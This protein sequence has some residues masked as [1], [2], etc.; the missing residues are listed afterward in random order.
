MSN[1]SSSSFFQEIRTRELNGFKVK[2]RPHFDNLSSDPGRIGAGVISIEHNSTPCPPLALSF[3][4]NVKNAHFI[5]VSDEDGYVSFYDTRKKLPSLSN[6]IEKTVE[7]RICDWVA[8]NNAIFDLC[9]IKDDLQI[10]TASGDQ[11][12][13]V[14]DAERRVCVNTLTGHTGS[15]KSLSPHP[16][17]NDLL[18]SG[19]RDGSFAHWDLRCN[20]TYGRS[21]LEPS[22]LSIAIVDK[23]HVSSQKKWGRRGKGGTLQADVIN[24]LQVASVSITSVLY[25]KDE[26]SIA[27]A[28]AVDRSVRLLNVVKLWDLRNYQYPINQTYPN[29]KQTTKER[30]HGI[31]CLS[32]D[33]NGIF[34]TASCMDNRIYLYH[35]L[36]LDK[37]PVNTFHGSRFDSFFVKSAI[38]SDAAHILSGS[39]DGNAYIWQVKKPQEGPI[40]LKG[41]EEEVTAVNWCPNEIGKIA[42]AADDFTVR[43]WDI[44]TG[45]FSS[46][47]SPSP[48]AIRRR[49]TAIPSMECRK[50]FMEEDAKNHRKAVS[51]SHPSEGVAIGCHSPSKEIDIPEISTPESAKKMLTGSFRKEILEM[52]TPDGS[53]NSPS[54]VL[55][56]P[57]SLKRKT[58]RDYFAAVS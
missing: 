42:T 5:A 23:A 34:L 49:I 22:T 29:T 10:V 35:V 6:C 44:Q 48:S 41:H 9:W 40:T 4:K 25:I 54:S 8:H 52:K 19:S 3:C 37:G 20:P 11:T 12:I 51:T 36:H 33:S 57:S 1:Y 39:S 47:S 43:I 27:T 2:K 18:V 53:I 14:W 50:L 58:I 31:S 17:N 46:T 56:P 26:V 21:S 15:V 55:N 38:S 32:Q 24:L 13:K 45:P 28:G 16:T 7:A 30:S